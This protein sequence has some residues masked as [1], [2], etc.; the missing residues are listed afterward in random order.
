VPARHSVLC[1]QLPT[2]CFDGDP[3]NGSKGEADSAVLDGAD[4][5]SRFDL[6]EGHDLERLLWPGTGSGDSTGLLQNFAVDGRR[7]ATVEP[8]KSA[9]SLVVK[10]DFPGSSNDMASTALDK[11][12][13][14]ERAQGAMASASR[15]CSRCCSGC[16]R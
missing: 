13:G 14:F 12:P 5:R 1:T 8:I 2:E 7:F 3:E 10:Q 11:C 9:P 4:R 6:R 15:R 16:W